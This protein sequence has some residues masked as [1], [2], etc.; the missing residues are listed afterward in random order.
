[1][2][3][4]EHL[5]LKPK[6]GCP[7]LHSGHM[8]VAV[9]ELIGWR[10][11]SIVPNVFWGLNLRHEADL[12]VLDKAGRFTEIEIKVTLSDLKADFKKRHGHYSKIIG[13]L[14]YAVPDK[15]VEYAKEHIPKESGLI[16]VRWNQYIGKFVATW[17]YTCKHQKGTEKPDAK[18][19]QKFLE[20]GCMRIWSLKQVLNSR[21]LAALNS[22]A[23]PQKELWNAN[24]EPLL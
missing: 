23:S 15:L 9:A 3:S 7:K 14:I 13:R 17:V 20:L 18:K 11:H 1:M 16:S 6:G 12:L 5:N 22:N 2:K 24:Y 19:I 10:E 21:A 4:K 8:E